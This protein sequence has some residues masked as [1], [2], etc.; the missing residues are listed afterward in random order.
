MHMTTNNRIYT[1]SKQYEIKNEKYVGKI[2]LTPDGIVIKN[3]SEEKTF[4]LDQLD[5]LMAYLAKFLL[6]NDEQEED[7]GVDN[8]LEQFRK[9][10]EAQVWQ[11]K[12]IETSWL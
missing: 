9:M 2:Y 6:K 1:C 5:E 4:K 3:D 10:K 7:E 12:L 11:E 8:M